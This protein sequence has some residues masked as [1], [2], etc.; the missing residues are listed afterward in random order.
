[1]IG[2]P[3]RAQC[4]ARGSVAIEFALVAPVFLMFLFLILEGGRMVFT[5][6]SVTEIATATARCAAIK[7]TGCTTAAN[8]QNWA[9][10][11]GLTRDNLH[12]APEN[13]EVITGTSCNGMPNMAKATISVAWKRA[14]TAFL[15]QS[16][17]PA[18]LTSIACF[19]IA[20]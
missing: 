9:I 8:A 10:S 3:R 11:R 20:S 12:L 15:P 1:M 6:Q 17:A 4:D 18:M 5:K 2:L 16:L 14:A 19:P 7:A 13:V